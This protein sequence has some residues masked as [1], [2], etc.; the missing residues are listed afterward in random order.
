M[1]GSAPRD[2]LEMVSIGMHLE[3]GVRQGRL[4]RESVPAGGSKKKDHEVNMVR[5]QLRQ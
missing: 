3:E 1:V 5:G 4:I 2:F